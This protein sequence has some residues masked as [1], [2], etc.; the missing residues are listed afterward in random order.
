MSSLYGKSTPVCPSYNSVPVLDVV[1][2]TGKWFELARDKSIKFEQGASC[3]TALYTLRE[4]GDVTVVN[5]SVR[6]DSSHS[7]I[8]GKARQT[9]K[10]GDL[11]VAFYG[12]EPVG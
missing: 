5:R 12:Q 7:F 1:G 10:G 8:E 3:V 2:Y 4:D 11:T 6:Q 9:G